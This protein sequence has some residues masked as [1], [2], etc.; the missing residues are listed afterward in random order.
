MG[1]PLLSRFQF[2]MIVCTGRWRLQHGP[3]LPPAHPPLCQVLPGPYTSTWDLA[4]GTDDT[5][6]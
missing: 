1:L 6:D 4:Q 3:F 5:R 2:S